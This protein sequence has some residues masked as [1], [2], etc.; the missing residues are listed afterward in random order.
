MNERLKARI[1]IF[2]RLILALKSS[3]NCADKNSVPMSSHFE[4][5]HTDCISKIGAVSHF[6]ILNLRLTKLLTCLF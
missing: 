1:F 5:W 3:S 2:A 6:G 4:T